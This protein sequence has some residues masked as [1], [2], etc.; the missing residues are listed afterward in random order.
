[1]AKKA[2]KSSG[3]SKGGQL[4]KTIAGVRIPKALRNAGPALVEF[5]QTDLGRMAVASALTAAA[6]VLVRNR[7]QAAA[8][9][10][11]GEAAADAGAGARD[12]A[13]AAAGLVAGV[14][15]E[16]ARHVL[17]A[18]LTGEERR[19]ERRD[20]DDRKDKEGRRYAHLAA[21]GKGSDK[22]K[23]KGRVRHH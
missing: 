16:A 14:V 2:K 12:A 1:M 17:P 7:P 20:G 10:R 11:T 8:L 23:K 3:K 13:G 18:S 6:D 22:G 4:P 9:A 19:D 21:A 15:A 5:A